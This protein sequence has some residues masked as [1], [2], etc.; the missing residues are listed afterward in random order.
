MQTFALPLETFLR[1]FPLRS[2]GIMWLLGAGTSASAGIPTAW[3]FIWEFKR[4]IYCSRNR[5]SPRQLQDISSPQIQQFLQQF[6]DAANRYPPLGA[7]EEYAHYFEEAYPSDGDRRKYIE[8][9]VLGGKP[10]FGHLVLAALM[11]GEKCEVV[12]TTN[13]DRVIEDACIE[14]ART[15]AWLRVASIDNP[16]IA[17]N[18]LS[19]I[20]YPLLVKLH[21]DFHSKRLK[22]TSNELRN[23]DVEMRRNLSV[24]CRTRGLAVVGYSG[25]DAS[26]MDAL[27]DVLDDA[28]GY[29][30]GLYWFHRGEGAPAAR[31]LQLLSK[32]RE[33]GVEAH[34]VSID[35]FDELMGDI[36]RQ[37][38]DLPADIQEA[39]RSRERRIV[40]IPLPTRKGKHPALRLNALPVLDWPRT[41]RKIACGIAGTKAVREALSTVDP[42]A[43]VAV[44]S[45]SGVLAYG[46][47]TALRQA[48]E[49]YG[50]TL[51][52][53]HAID[54][55][56]LTF[57]SAELGLLYE[58]VALAIARQA[59]L[60]KISGRSGHT[61]AVNPSAPSTMQPRLSL[62]REATPGGIHGVIPNTRIRWAEAIQIKLEYRMQGL[63]MVMLPTI[64]AERAS[65]ASDG[66]VRAEFIRK[67]LATRYNRSMNSLLDAWVSLLL[68][69]NT[70]QD[71]APE[72]RRVQFYAFG[73]QDGVD[74]QFTL[75][76]V[77]AFSLREPPDGGV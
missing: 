25:R 2:R 67:R 47:D 62:L 13:F 50:I 65:D 41:C 24:A 35:T 32:A 52:D 60:T 43:C 71:G 51:V 70:S 58:A 11:K 23:Q 46:S 49:P 68:G 42:G 64:W 9:K 30:H 36:F 45:Q 48:L 39:L 14:I 26:V 55:Q 21:G 44:R 38:R 34:L 74:A 56:R 16:Q 29:P 63:W 53:V 31:V 4:E 18:V 5:V 61:L 7:D 77:T 15:T 12:W 1:S 69:P 28:G 33:S 66:D 75:G 8:S 22:N 10:S 3:Q 59:P 40:S 76:S 72:R 6:F 19:E 57:D 54:P 20:T 37:I 17:R 27:E 73:N